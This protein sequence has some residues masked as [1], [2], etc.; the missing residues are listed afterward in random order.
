M[1][2]ERRARRALLGYFYSQIP[3]MLGIVCVAAAVRTALPHP[4]ASASV[5][6][7]LFLSGGVAGFL[8]GDLFF[9]TSL[10]LS[11]SVWRL[12]AL[13]LVLALTAAGTAGSVMLLFG[14]VAAVL[15]AALAAEAVRQAGRALPARPRP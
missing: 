9:R 13:P 5:A 10:E 15:I 12:A 1:P 2:G 7:A 11:R 14:G 6:R 3:M 8:I 4:T